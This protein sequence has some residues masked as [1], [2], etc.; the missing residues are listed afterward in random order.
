MKSATVAA[1]GVPPDTDQ[2]TLAR[3]M[4]IRIPPVHRFILIGGTK[5]R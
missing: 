1:L 2:E 3:C 5:Q 4:K